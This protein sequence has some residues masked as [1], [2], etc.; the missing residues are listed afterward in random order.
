MSD[1]LIA[2]SLRPD[3]RDEMIRL[4]CRVFRSDGYERYTRYLDG[5]PDYHFD[6]TRVVVCDHRLIATLRVWDRRMRIGT[7]TI[8]V[9]GIGG[10]GTHPDFRK[11]G[12]AT[13]MLHDVT[14]Y[15][16]DAD[17]ELGVLF[18]E[19]PCS[20]YSRLGWSIL[21]LAGFTLTIG[22][23]E[24]KRMDFPMNVL[25]FCELRD[26]S[27]AMELYARHNQSLSGTLVRS[28]EYW[29]CAP[30]RIRGVLPTVVVRTSSE[31]VGYLNC[32]F[33]DDSFIIHEVVCSEKYPDALLVLMEFVLKECR[34]RNI[35]VVRGEFCY[36]HPF[37]QK[38]MERTAA[39]LVLS[40]NGEMMLYPVNLSRLI[41]RL[42]PMWQSRLE[43]SLNRPGPVQF[44]LRMGQQ[45]CRV[46]L[47]EDGTLHSGPDE[48]NQTT[49][50]ISQELLLRMIFGETGWQRVCSMNLVNQQ[51]FP[52]E[53]SKLFRTIF[54]EQPLTFWSPDHF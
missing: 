22:K 8:R 37:V 13:V 5:D 46:Q 39:D 45:S 6:Q 33:T 4:Q 24:E 2:R 31:I 34:D 7:V 30:S 1:S 20:F 21:P 23:F 42:L 11:R 35:C 32:E 43:K 10:V 15:L 51:A 17:Y 52:T 53:V 16:F 29:T 25:P 50:P 27:G 48:R 36:R 3:E 49:V 47:T 14:Q 38:M 44:V 19:I 41:Q 54:P 28:P 40:G 12:A 9:G 26:L 18:S